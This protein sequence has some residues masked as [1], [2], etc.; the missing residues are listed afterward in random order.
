MAVAN[1]I[2]ALNLTRISTSV[3]NSKKQMGLTNQVLSNRAKS[4]QE[5]VDNQKRLI[6]ES[7][8]YYRRREEIDEK[9]KQEA[10]L[11][12]PDTVKTINANNQQSLSSPSDK[13][14]LGRL[15]GFA[16]YLAAG[17]ILTRLP[18][19][20][21]F[22]EDFLIRLQTAK[23][24]VGN[25]FNST[26]SSFQSFGKLL[27]G[28]LTNVSR[29]DLGGAYT[30]ITTDFEDLT[31]NLY[32]MGGSLETAFSFIID[33]LGFKLAEREQSQ[34]QQST[35]NESQDAYSDNGTAPGG[36]PM[37]TGEVA[38]LPL[39]MTEKQAFATIYELAKKYGDPM[40]ELTAAQSMYESGYL[41]SSMARLDNNPFGQR[42]SGSAGSIDGWARY[43]TLDDAVK[44]HVER[45]SKNWNGYR[46]LST[47]NSPME[48]LRANIETYAPAK[49]NNQ[50]KYLSGVAGILVTMGF[51]PNGKNQSK[52]LNSSARVQA[53]KPY[54]GG[55]TPISGKPSG[56][57]TSIGSGHSLDSS[58]ADSFM[59]MRQEAAKQGVNL[60]LTSSYRSREKQEYLYNLYLQGKGNLAARPGS[61]LHEKGLAIDV[62]SD[63]SWVQKYGPK[64]GWINTG[65]SFSQ[66][67]PWHFDFKGSVSPSS[68][69]S[70]QEEKTPPAIQRS[71]ESR[72]KNLD[73]E[74]RG[75]DYLVIDQ[76]SSRGT[77]M[78]QSYGS[79]SSP[80]ARE[81][82]ISQAFA[83]NIKKRL[84]NDL[85]YV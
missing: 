12:A 52:D 47:Y 65:M 34:S 5:S 48:G 10:A 44:F 53:V 42:G 76:R 61:S 49:E 63:I 50:P 60:T 79:S 4:I 55:Q 72:G 21:K 59:K 54:S 30:S 46:G 28:V 27:G 64:F 3:Y 2:P 51:N 71:T 56:K 22:G 19:L 33:P 40:P 9:N 15:L 13:G 73:M 31:K 29:L 78:Q 58:A 38:P 83:K 36:G 24:I 45:W 1:K 25:F 39:G 8:L 7:N 23:D 35:A 41:K 11:E 75:E 62:A 85:A 70:T 6:S 69:Q 14:F 66:K 32:K 77:S 18:Q 37:P 43:K 17:W 68:T 84:M 20:I 82:D 16:G 26:L 67:E 81:E 74:R 80:N 57:I